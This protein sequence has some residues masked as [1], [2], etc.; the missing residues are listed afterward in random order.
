MLGA[1]E[2]GSASKEYDKSMGLGKVVR[3]LADP[4]G[5]A[6]MTKQKA[7]ISQPNH[8]QGFPFLWSPSN[9]S[10]CLPQSQPVSGGGNT[11]NTAEPGLAFHQHC[12]QGNILQPGQSVFDLDFDH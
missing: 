3:E 1:Q 10:Y 12:Q 9:G 4:K 2:L 5:K 8:Q 7:R 11:S 6:P